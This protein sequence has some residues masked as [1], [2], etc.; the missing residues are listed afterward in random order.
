VLA[1]AVLTR[2]PPADE[3]FAGAH[4]GGDR[5]RIF[6]DASK[7][8]EHARCCICAEAAGDVDLAVSILQDRRILPEL[9][10]DRCRAFGGDF[11]ALTSAVVPATLFR[12]PRIVTETGFSRDRIDAT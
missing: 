12:G 4:E 9:L 3:R 2:L 6:R 10:T 7:D 1:L 11:A 8:Y 5:E